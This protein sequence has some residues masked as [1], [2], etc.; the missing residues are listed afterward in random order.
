MLFSAKEMNEVYQKEFYVVYRAFIALAKKVQQS[1][2][3]GRSR[4]GRNV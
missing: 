1:K 2:P 4:N 3:H